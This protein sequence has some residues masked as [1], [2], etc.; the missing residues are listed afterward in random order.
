MRIMQVNAS[1]LSKSLI[2][3]KHAKK[4]LKWGYLEIV[5]ASASPSAV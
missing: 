5:I 3:L 4:P 2:Q 1:G